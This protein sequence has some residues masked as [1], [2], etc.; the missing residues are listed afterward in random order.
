MDKKAAITSAIISSI[1]FIIISIIAIFSKVINKWQKGGKKIYD[2]CV[3]GGGIAG[4]TFAYRYAMGGARV[5]LLEKEER[6]G[7]RASKEF[8]WHGTKIK[9]GAG[10]I[11]PGDINLLK[12]INEIGLK[13]VTFNVTPKSLREIP[14]LSYR[15]VLQHYTNLLSILNENPPHSTESILSYL[16]RVNAADILDIVNNN[17]GYRDFQNTAALDFIFCYPF[18]DMYTLEGRPAL[19]IEGGWQSLID[20]LFEKVIAYDGKVVLGQEI[21]NIDNKNICSVHSA[22]GKIYRAKNIVVAGDLSLIQKLSLSP[23]INNEIGAVPFTRG[24][25]YFAGGT[26]VK[27]PDVCLMPYSSLNNMIIPFTN[28]VVMTIYSDSEK[29]AA[30]QKIYTTKSKE[31][32]IKI[33]D[34]L[35]APILRGQ[36]S[37]D[38]VWKYWPIG[39]HYYRNNVL[40]SG[41]ISSNNYREL[42]RRYNKKELMN[43]APNV[44]ICG[45]I[46]AVSQGWVEGAVESAVM[47]E[48]LLASY[49]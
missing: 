19:A 38:F 16:K 21:I 4:L 29:A 6:F 5:I 36:K 41:E 1:L 31:E 28:E 35:A 27:L 45:E 8:Y 43:P 49:I 7:G 32:I 25:S 24:F 11:R 14:L 34:D 47:L 22:A 9:L 2:F 15:E 48:E 13:T 33:V 42:R 18:M 46:V 12:L 44:Y 39:I 23:R 40:P 10:I 3:I 37:N 26:K 30:L 20:K 17:M